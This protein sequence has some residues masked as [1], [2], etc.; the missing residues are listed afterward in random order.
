MTYQ[1][2]VRRRC[3]RVLETISRFSGIFIQIVTLFIFMKMLLNINC[4]KISLKNILTFIGFNI[5]TMIIYNVEY[6]GIYTI[7]FFVTIIIGLSTIYKIELTKSFFATSIFMI[8]LFLA[9]IITS[10]VFVSFVTAEEL[11]TKYFLFSN[12]SVGLITLSIIKIPKI[13]AGC[14]EVIKINAKKST[15][16]TIVFLILLMI[17]LSIIVFMLSINYKLSF[18]FALSVIGILIFLILAVIFLREKYEKEKLIDKY[19]QMLEYV[20]TFEEWIDNENMNI[21]ESK[22]QLATLRGMVL[23]NKKAVNYIDNIIKERVN[24]DERINGELKRLPK[25]GLKGLIYYKLTIANNN[26]VKLFIDVSSDIESKFS[27][28][29]EEENKILCRLIGIFLDNAI[30]ASMESEKRTVFCEIY[31]GDNNLVI[32]ISNTF[33][34][35][36][37]L[38]KMYENGYSTKGKNRGK[39]LYLATKVAN[40]NKIFILDNRI[41]N[42]YYIQKITIKK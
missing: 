4:Y 34:K 8:I 16:D 29:T 10:S 35:N 19:D 13:N 41:I 25:G 7:I 11:R 17:A 22:N 24:I 21:H 38:S 33:L 14:N 5:F 20:T 31:L 37:E 42:D 28:L 39:G 15:I 36:V 1:E 40:K 18:N 9:D 3:L 32:A 23:K 26:D 27:L 12:L 6:S 2:I 30:E